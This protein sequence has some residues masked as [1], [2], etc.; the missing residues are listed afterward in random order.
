MDKKEYYNQ[1][2]DIKYQNQIQLTS[3]FRFCGNC[4][5][6]DTYRGCSHG[7]KYCFANNRMAKGFGG[8]NNMQLGDHKAIENLF[9]AAFESKKPPTDLSVELMRRRVPFHLGG[10]SDPFQP[11][12]ER[13]QLTLKFLR[14]SKMFKYPVV[15][16]SK[17]G[18]EPTEEYFDVLD[19]ALHTWQISLLGR[20]EGYV[21]KFETYSSTPDQRISFI[22]KL[23]EKNF[24]VAVRIQPLVDLDQADRVLKDLYGYIDYC[25]VEHLKLPK[26]NDK[27]WDTVLVHL[28]NDYKALLRSSPNKPEFELNS[29]VKL[30][31]VLKLKF[32]Y[33]G[34]K[35]G[36]GDNDLHEYSDSLNCCGI[37]TMPPAF[38]NWLKYNSMYIKMTGDRSQ[39]IPSCKINGCFLSDQLKK[40][41]G[42]KDYVDAYYNTIYE[43][44]RQ[45]SLFGSDTPPAGICGGA[46]EGNGIKSQLDNKKKK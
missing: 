14:L 31:N 20:D 5:R 25:T 19:P 46:P 27:I 6:V 2:N 32:K 23:K 17:I 29:R 13:H 1:V 36:C 35:F 4:F 22:K 8:M 43:D 37:D 42:Y 12:E 44:D 33:P 30:D 7:C 34:L 16:S 21:R 39:W 41:W 45:L 24:W 9:K 18:W 15:I 28:S 40:G 38:E 26:F 3:Q 10:M 11:R